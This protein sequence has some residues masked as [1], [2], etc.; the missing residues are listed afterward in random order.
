MTVRWR[1]HTAFWRHGVVAR[2]YCARGKHG[3]DLLL[4]ANMANKR[5][6]LRGDAVFPARLPALPAG[7]V[8]RMKKHHLVYCIARH[9]VQHVTVY[10]TIPLMVQG[11]L[12]TLA[13]AAARALHCRCSLLR[14]DITVYDAIYVSA[15]AANAVPNGSRATTDPHKSW[16][17]RHASPSKPR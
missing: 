15:V 17:S 1:R 4:E 13:D 11:M 2:W 10:I 8:M 6:K 12:M 9:A 16:P 14:T 7:A 3:N 5:N